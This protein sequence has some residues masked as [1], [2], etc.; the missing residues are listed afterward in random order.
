MEYSYPQLNT[1]K[2]SYDHI[3]ISG[4][5]DD[6]RKKLQIDDYA[7]DHQMNWLVD[8]IIRYDQVA[9]ME[10]LIYEFGY[11]VSEDFIKR[12]ALKLASRNEMKQLLANAIG[13]SF[14]ELLDSDTLCEIFKMAYKNNNINMIIELIN[15]GFI[16]NGE[17]AKDMINESTDLHYDILKIILD[18]GLK[19]DFIDEDTLKYLIQNRCYKII[20]L[21]FQYG[22]DFDCLNKI[23]IP[24]E[25][26]D[27]YNLL[28]DL[29]I[30]PKIISFLLAQ[31]S[32]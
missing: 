22:V 3:I 7:L 18:H 21:L 24:K 27:M 28:V 4:S 5:I 8:N 16:V 20:K 23:A 32:E 9:M 14:L 10:M 19:I 25:H 30:N 31:L 26:D 1:L 29:E 11:V 13:K 15:F 2:D 17:D 12:Y 6:F